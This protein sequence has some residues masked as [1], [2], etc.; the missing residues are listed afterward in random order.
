MALIVQKFGGTSVAS[1]ERIKAVGKII[2]AEHNAGNN[3]VVVVSAMAGVTNS[4]ISK[5]YEILNLQSTENFQEYGAIVSSGEIL[6]SGLLALELQKIGLKG[7]SFQGWQIPIITDDIFL[8][9][10]VESVNSALLTESVKNNV[11]PIITGFQGI[12]KNNK[13]TTLGKGGSDTTAALLGAAIGADRVDIYTDVRGVFD[14]DPRVIHNAHKIDKMSAQLM[15]E[16]SSH[17]AKILH[18]RA[19]LAAYRYKFDMR[20]LS[21]FEADSGTLITNKYNDKNHMEH[22]EIT[23]ITSNKN[24]LQIIIDFATKDFS[25]ITKILSK[26]NL[27]INKFEILSPGKISLISDLSDKNKIESILETMQSDKKISNYNIKSDIATVTMVGY[28]IKNDAN[29]CFEITDI[30]NQNEFQP[31]K[32]DLSETICSIFLEEKYTET[33]IKLLHKALIG[34]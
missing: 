11:I 22:R 33:A 32:I 26:A 7:R 1:I 17:G 13:L 3:V 34:N 31:I 27:T 8:N 14:S 12:T 25:D 19:A 2:F 20:I 9:A 15:L 10:K 18:S 24:L 4:L 21:S 23:A 30:L 29:L 28:G 6:T 5:C 16:L